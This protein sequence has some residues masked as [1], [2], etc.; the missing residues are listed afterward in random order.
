VRDALINV[1]PLKDFAYGLRTNSDPNA[2]GIAKQ[3]NYELVCCSGHG[4]NGTL[5]ALQQSIRPDL[6]TE[7]EL[8]SCTGIWTVYYKSSRGIIT[9]DNEYHAYLIISLESRT[10]V[11]QTGDD[12]G[13]VTETVD[14]NVQACTIAAGNLFGRRRVIQVY[15][16][17]ARVLDGS[18]MTQEL[19]FTMHSSESSL[20]S[21]PLAAASASIAD[22]YVLLKM[23]DGTVRLLV[24][25]A[26]S[27]G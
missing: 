25:E 4:K 20:T 3:S 14:Y 2:A 26:L 27:H 8:P 24:G 12:L 7:V 23:V 18:F 11:L 16:K 22:P 13:E 15:A 6:I 1:G 21:E 19:N 5:S 10:M 9:E 17:G